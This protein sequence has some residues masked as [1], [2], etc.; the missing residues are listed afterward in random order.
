MAGWTDRFVVRQGDITQDTS[1]AIVNAAN[2]RLARGG[3][4]CGAIHAAAGPELE[5][6]CRRIGHCATGA[7]VITGAYGLPCRRVIHTVGPVYG[8]GPDDD[9]EAELL[10]SCY[11]ES[12]RLAAEHGLRTIAFPSLSTGIYGYP[13]DRA[14]RVAVAAIRDALAEL[15]AVEKVTLVCFSAGDLEV[16]ERARAELA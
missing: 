8:G 9:R 6:E 14:S 13:V 16:Y 15:P 4:V 2:E 12:L 10:A 7:A 5:E 3:G 11:R 1:D